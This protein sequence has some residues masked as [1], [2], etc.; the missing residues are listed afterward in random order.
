MK[1]PQLSLDIDQLRRYPVEKMP[2]VHVTESTVR[3]ENIVL[4]HWFEPSTMMVYSIVRYRHSYV[5]VI[6]H[7]CCYFGRFQC[8]ETNLLFMKQI[9]ENL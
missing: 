6:L 2:G 9:I 5:D 4:L 8:Y 3:A 1:V 7:S